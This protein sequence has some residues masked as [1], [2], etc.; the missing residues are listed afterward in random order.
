MADGH[1]SNAIDVDF[2]LERHVSRDEY[3]TSELSVITGELAQPTLS[4]LTEAAA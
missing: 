1:L 3:A 2:N 4:G